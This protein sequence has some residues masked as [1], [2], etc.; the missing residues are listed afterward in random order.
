MAKTGPV[1]F[2]EVATKRG[3]TDMTQQMANSIGSMATQLG[4]QKAKQDAADRAELK[5]M[6]AGVTKPGKLNKLLVT[7]AQ[8]SFGETTLG[9][10]KLYNS[11][12]PQRSIKGQML[13][14]DY[15]EKVRGDYVA[16]SV[17]YDILEEESR[18]PNLW[19][20]KKAQ[21]LVE[22][23]TKANNEEEFLKFQEQD[24]TPEYFNPVTLQVN[25][26]EAKEKI[27][28]QKT[29]DGTIGQIQSMQ[30]GP[31]KLEVIPLLEEEA[32][33]YRK[34]YGISPNSIEQVIDASFMNNYDFLEQYVDNRDLTVKNVYSM[35]P[36][37]R[38]LVKK[39][40]MED[41]SKFRDVKYPNANKTYVNVTTGQAENSTFTFVP[42][43][44]FVPIT[45]AVGG[46][47]VTTYAPVFGNIKTQG[48][49][50]Y[51]I[52]NFK[53]A[54]D[55][56]GQPYKA[57]KATEAELAGTAIRPYY[58]E[59]G[60]EYVITNYEDLKKA[61]GFKTYYEFNGGDLSV[62]TANE[63]NLQF[64][65]GG[66]DAVAVQRDALQKQKQLEVK[67]N[68]YH[69]KVKAG[70]IKNPLLYQKISDLAQN[71]ISEDDYVNFVQS[72]KFD[73]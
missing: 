31:E 19:R 71:K 58:I 48:S 30:M 42:N 10:Q 3:V 46:K 47:N 18:K 15:L 11:N 53:G 33:Y 61:V 37:E 55:R 45:K 32:N 60:Q 2:L 69:K 66:K 56:Q 62:P 63:P 43:S 59:G 52:S 20:P 12:D 41:G 7:D 21:K 1:S 39:S 64:N 16:R 4:K 29:I 24:P 36:E 28:I 49:Q 26:P 40:L 34:N 50:K 54:V 14:N 38:T 5:Q 8:K 27:D 22:Q 25:L 65:V 67:F 35:T 57:N 72:F 68:E 73:K 13:A 44:A 17:N 51:S 70:T 23:Y 6:L 9:L